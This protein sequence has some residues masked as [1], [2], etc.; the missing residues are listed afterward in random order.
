MHKIKCCALTRF[1]NLLYNLKSTHLFEIL[2]FFNFLHN[3][4]KNLIR[5]YEFYTIEYN[6]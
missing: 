5:L 6:L 4:I 1:I 2:L 3:K